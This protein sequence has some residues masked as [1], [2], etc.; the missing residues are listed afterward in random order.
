MTFKNITFLVFLVGALSAYFYQ[1]SVD[2][3][4]GTIS[5]FFSQDGGGASGSIKLGT[6]SV[7][8]S[9]SEDAQDG[10]SQ[11][12]EE[13][14]EEKVKEAEEVVKEEEEDSKIED[15]PPKSR[16]HCED[17]ENDCNQWA[18]LGECEANPKFMLVNCPV[19]CKSCPDDERR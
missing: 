4:V 7:E 11:T 5:A 8:K 14:K 15:V 16:P 9:F 3:I 19:S 18:D 10:T 13:E 6:V 12:T 2:E 17:K 1:G